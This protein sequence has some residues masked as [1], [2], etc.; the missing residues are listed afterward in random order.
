M[1]PLLPKRQRLEKAKQS[2]VDWRAA[3]TAQY[4]ALFALRSV[5]VSSIDDSQY[6]HALTYADL[7]VE[8]FRELSYEE[9]KQL[10]RLVKCLDYIKQ[11][12]AV[13]V[14][15]MATALTSAQHEDYIASFDLE[16]SHVEADETNEM[17]IFL[18]DY[19]E[20]IKQ[21]DKYTRIANMLRRTKKKDGKGQTAFGRNEAKA[22]G[23]Y[24]DALMDL[25]NALDTDPQTSVGAD[26]RLANKIQAWLDRPVDTREG[27]APD[28][29][30]E[31]VPR[32]RGIKS[33]YA[34]TT[35]EPV[36]GDR[37]RKYWRQREALVESTLQ[38]LYETYD[39]GIAILTDEQTKNLREKLQ[40]LIGSK[41]AAAK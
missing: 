38:L 16:M 3:R 10:L 28:I 22:F 15:L 36:V 31:G 2:E 35:A 33:V 20:T 19:L 32:V 7:S 4:E 11:E 1:L 13:P 8:A 21:G 6:I 30:L 18:R 39:D 40:K 26:E 17:P 23:Y 9:H 25:V 24:E 27:C 12:K 41:A 34:M 5:A 37:L 14:N 29:S